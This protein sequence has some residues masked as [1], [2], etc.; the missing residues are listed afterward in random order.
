MRTRIG[1]AG[2]SYPDWNGRVYPRPKPK[3]FDPLRYLAQLFDT[4]EINSPFYAVPRAE[5]C[6]S[7]AERVAARPEFRFTAKLH[8]SFTHERLPDSEREL[9]LQAGDFVRALEPLAA[10]GRLAALLVQ[11]PFSFA[12]TD[13]HRRHLRRLVDAL[14]SAAPPAVA[15]V[16]ELRRAEW[17][18]PE[19][20]AE[21]RARGIAL[22]EIDL[23]AAR[24]H[25]PAE[26]EPT[27]ALAYLRLHGRN[28]AAWFDRRAGR[29]QRYDYSYGPEELDRIS[30]RIQRLTRQTDAT[31]VIT[32]NHFAGQ[33]VANALELRQRVEPDSAR[34]LRIPEAL[35]QSYPRLAALRAAPAPQDRPPGE[36]GSLFDV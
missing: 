16:L 32:N 27:A 7:W 35:L 22:A 4:I 17:F 9:E 2:W 33:A 1:P 13:E 8:R 19:V 30:E 20:L 36:Q 6:A 3:G 25:P 34:P 31:Y 10:A 29:D 11:F 21:F 15:L 18:A 12:R 23:P 26:F 14:Q 5:Q 28:Q 24:E